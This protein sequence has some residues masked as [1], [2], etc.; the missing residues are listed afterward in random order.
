VIG[1][2]DR[3]A[4]PDQHVLL[5]GDLGENH[6]FVDPVR[7]EV[8]SVIDFGETAAGLWLWD[9]LEFHRPLV[10]PILDGY[11]VATDEREEIDHLVITY[12]LLK[13]VPWAAK[14]HARGE[15]EVLVWLRRTVEMF[16]E[17]RS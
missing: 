1:A 6:V 15:P 10:P 11:G 16:D 5:H 4:E 14:W 12:A 17:T 3:V 13:A 7:R 9:L 8:T 2:L